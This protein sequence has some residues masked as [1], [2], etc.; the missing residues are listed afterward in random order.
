[1][2][3]FG[4][5]PLVAQGE[6]TA[7]ASSD[8]AAAW[9]IGLF[10]ASIG[11]ATLRYNVIKGVDWSDWPTYTLNKALG[12][13]AI[14]LLL[15][16]TINLGRA[17]KPVAGLLFATSIFAVGHSLL[18]LALLDPIYYA[19]F[20]T[21]R[22]LTPLAGASLAI[23]GLCMAAFEAGG[24]RSVVWSQPI[25]HRWL[26]SLAFGAG[27]H[28]ALPGVAGWLEPQRWPGGLPPITLLAFLAGLG[29]LMSWRQRRRQLE[30]S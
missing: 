28:A 21:D 23:G 19:I 5:P 1:M 26:A 20:Y 8:T 9:T 18:S 22:K 27:L 11:Y 25:R 7:P 15:V 13:T 30:R 17:G 3:E 6:A 2:I 4:V 29:A 16:A 12:T 14:L 10:A 24:R